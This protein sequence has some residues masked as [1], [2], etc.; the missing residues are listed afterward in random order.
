MNNNQKTFKDI[1][2][3]HIGSEGDSLNILDELEN[4]LKYNSHNINYEITQ[5]KEFKYKKTITIKD[6]DNNNETIFAV[7]DIAKTGALEIS[8]QTRAKEER[9]DESSYAQYPNWK[10]RKISKYPEEQEY[11]DLSLLSNFTKCIQKNTNDKIMIWSSDFEKGKRSQTIVK[12][13]TA[14]IE[15]KQK[16]FEKNYE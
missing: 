7:E 6:E 1:A 2:Y 3:F 15:E 8:I 5:N 11:R 13:I 10:T 14:V 16:T 9:Y 12:N 4:F